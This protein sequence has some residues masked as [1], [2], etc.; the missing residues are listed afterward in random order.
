ME[1]REQR[2]KSLAWVQKMKLEGSACAGSWFKFSP[3]ARAPTA[4]VELMSWEFQGRENVGTG[5]L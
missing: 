2:M 1:G 3:V 5:V 4:C